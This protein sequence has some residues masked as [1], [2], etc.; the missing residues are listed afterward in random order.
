[1]GDKLKYTDLIGRTVKI[2]KMGYRTRYE[3]EGVI[4]KVEDVKL[5]IRLGDGKN[6]WVEKLQKKDYMLVYGGSE[7][8]TTTTT[9]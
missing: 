4:C 5:N 6:V 8:T 1:M 3:Y 2:V 7:T 9:S